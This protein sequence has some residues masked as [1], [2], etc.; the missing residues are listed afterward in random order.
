MLR[1]EPLAP[2]EHAAILNMVARGGVVRPYTANEA[3]GPGE[4][5]EILETSTNEVHRLIRDGQLTPAS[6]D[7]PETVLAKDVFALKA[8]RGAGGTA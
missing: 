4:I 8:S 7:N 5:A 1:S 3:V 2:E 6:D